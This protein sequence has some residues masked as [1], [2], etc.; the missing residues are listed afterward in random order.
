MGYSPWGGKVRHDRVTNFTLLYYG[1]NSS[2]GGRRHALDRGDSGEQQLGPDYR[3]LSN[4]ESWVGAGELPGRVVELPG[5]GTNLPP[6]N[7][8]IP[9]YASRTTSPPEDSTPTQVGTLAGGAIPRP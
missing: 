9:D 5:W 3:P 8:Q 7:S 4:V 1:W 6:V 2:W